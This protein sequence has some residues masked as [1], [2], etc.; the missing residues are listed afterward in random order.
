[1]KSV[2]KSRKA[3]AFWREMS[4]GFRIPPLGGRCRKVGM[5]HSNVILSEWNLY[6]RWTAM[7]IQVRSGIISNLFSFINLDMGNLNRLQAFSQLSGNPSRC[8]SKMCKMYQV[9]V[10]GY[11]EHTWIRAGLITKGEDFYDD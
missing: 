9:G 10:L 1:M 4:M 8:L 11:A 7:N 3:A 5:A 2:L 6:H